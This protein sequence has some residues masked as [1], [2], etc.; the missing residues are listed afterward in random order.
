MKNLRSTIKKIPRAVSIYH[1]LREFIKSIPGTVIA[2]HKG[3]FYVRKIK[4]YKLLYLHFGSH[5]KD[6]IVI[7]EKILHN[8]KYDDLFQLHY[9][10]QP[11]QYNKVMHQIAKINL[12]QIRKQQK[13]KISFVL[14]DSAMWCGDLLYQYL[15]NDSKF[16]VE[17]LLSM[18]TDQAANTETSRLNFEKGVEKF[19]KKNLNVHVLYPSD[20]Y[21][22]DADILFYLTPYFNVLNK[23]LSFKNIPL[24]CLICF[25]TYGISDTRGFADRKSVV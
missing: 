3:V 9:I 5:S 13:V 4:A 7:D 6:N 25:V 22:T 15:E 12:N 20:D 19:R 23:G 1:T 14:Y 16:D 10:M 8:I 18:R 24:N 11:N 2:Y 17:I 21:Q